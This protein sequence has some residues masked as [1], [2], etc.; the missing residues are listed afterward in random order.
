[1]NTRLQDQDARLKKLEALLNT[2]LSLVNQLEAIRQEIANIRGQL[3]VQANN[4]GQT[5]KR[6]QDFYVDLDNRL[7]KL[8][9]IAQPPAAAPAASAPV[10][11][12]E[13][14]DYEAGLN[15]LK[16]GKNIDAAVNLKTFIRNYP[17][18]SYLPSANFWL[19]AT[20]AQLK[21]SASA[22]DTYAKMAETWPDDPLAPDALLGQADAQQ[23]LK[24]TRGARTTLET[25][26]AKY[27]NS[28]AAK[29]ARSRLGKK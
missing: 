14:Q 29:T 25:L 27:P 1:M 23:A 4:I 18:S 21:D 17:K 13:A 26:V 20:Y 11:G 2:Q 3:E 16:A 15:A 8:E 6:Q 10:A 22:R 12:T 9:T 28:D 7:R 24:E 19:A 5:Q